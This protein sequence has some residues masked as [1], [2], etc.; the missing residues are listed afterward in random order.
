MLA[1]WGRR[2]AAGVA[3]CFLED[4][5]FQIVPFPPYRGRVAIKEAVAGFI[6]G[7]SYVEFRVIHGGAVSPSVVMNER[8]DI[9]R[10]DGKE[11]QVPVMGVFEI[12][13]DLVREWRDYFD[14]AL[15]AG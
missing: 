15:M 2:D 7:A 14:S 11:F 5:V 4:G 6:S 9:F 13:G 1:A 12:E 10:K 3:A 8:V